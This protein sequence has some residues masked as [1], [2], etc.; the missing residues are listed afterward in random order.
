MSRVIFELSTYGMHS[1]LK[2]KPSL[3][4]FRGDIVMVT[5]YPS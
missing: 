5:V 2:T 4:T 3:L 1:H